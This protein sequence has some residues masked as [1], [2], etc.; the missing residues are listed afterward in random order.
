L[1]KNEI[2][3]DEGQPRVIF[4][5]PNWEDF[6]HMTFR[7]IRQCGAGS[8]QVA[9]RLRA[10]IENLLE[11]LPQHRHVALQQELALLDRALVRLHLIPEDLALARIA[12]SQGLG[13]ESSA[14]MQE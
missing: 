1:R 9:R 7:E 6:V 3:D 2:T 13:G 10:V 11:T 14:Q 8:L 4:R 12:D 5:T